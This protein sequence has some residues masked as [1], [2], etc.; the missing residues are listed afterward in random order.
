M[1]Q[2]ILLD[3]LQDARFTH[4]FVTALFGFRPLVERQPPPLHQTEDRRDHDE[5]QQRRLGHPAN[6]RHSDALHNVRPGT[7]APLMGS[8]PAMMATTVII[9]ERTRSIA[10]S[11]MAS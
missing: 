5:C 3:G 7:G 4:C 6:H 9:L 8:R 1:K 11:M 10:L 2:S